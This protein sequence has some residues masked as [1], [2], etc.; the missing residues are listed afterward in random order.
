MKS[1]YKIQN[2]YLQIADALLNNGG[3]INEEIEK[4]LA[5]NQEELENKSTNYAL[6]IRDFEGKESIIDAE[7]KRLQ[8]LKK[9]ITSTREKLES[10]ILTAMQ[11][12]GVE[13][14]DGDLIHLSV[15]K[16]PAS[17]EIDDE[18]LIPKHLKTLVPESY[19]PN[20]VAIKAQLQ[21]GNPVF[22]CRLVDDKK[23]LKIK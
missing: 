7:I 14:I 11:A 4:S 10:N 5:I 15:Q 17:V 13:K 12:F 19:K 22:G 21:A 16:N 8:E 2:E 20:R 3:E 18:K 6:I 1:L 9:G 23:R